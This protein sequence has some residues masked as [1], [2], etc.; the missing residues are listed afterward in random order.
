MNRDLILSA[1]AAAAFHGALLLGIP[2]NAVPVPEV[3]K[4]V[5]LVDFVMPKLDREPPEPV[6]I[7]KSETRP[8]E[9]PAELV[10]RLAEVP[11]IARPTDITTQ[12]VPTPAVDAPNVSA[13]PRNI[14]GVGT[15]I[16]RTAVISWAELDQK[17]RTRAQIAPVYPFDAK[18]EGRTGTV[19][20]EF[21]VD[22]SGRV[23][24]PRIVETTD[25]VFNDATIAAVL[26]WR[27]E[28]GTRH[29]KAVRFRMIAPVVFS[30]N[31]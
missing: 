22:E 26:K 16:H 3:I 23:S 13:I 10:P 28:P 11:Q 19:H 7:E 14:V 12:F 2:R 5:A 9:I 25:R 1:A 8:N 17:P 6:E 29:G 30:L 15:E 20:V 21:T 27:F 4:S 31:D 24:D 18:R